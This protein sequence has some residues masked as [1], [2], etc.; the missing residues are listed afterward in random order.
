[1]ILW[2]IW[3]IPEHKM[4]ITKRRLRQII[5]EELSALYKGLDDLYVVIGNA[6]RGQQN[7]WPKSDEPEAYPKDEA[8]R[9]AKELNSKRMG[10][11]MQVH[12][13]V[14][15]LR[16]ATEFVSPGNLAYGGLTNLLK[17]YGVS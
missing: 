8:E 14:K 9:I 2:K 6:G 16:Q 15:P 5:K 7:M 1:M 10:G 3:Q 17:K 12:Y 13:H 4:K 11:Y